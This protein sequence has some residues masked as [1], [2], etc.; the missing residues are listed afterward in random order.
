[1]K[2]IIKKAK[3]IL[4]VLCWIV[5]CVLAISIVMAFVARINGTNPTIL[6]YSVFRISSGSMEPELLVG[7]V[8]LGKSAT[9]PEEIKVGDVVTYKGSG[10]LEGELITHKVIIA[11]HEE[12]GT[13]MLQ[14]QGTANDIP[15]APIEAD[16]VISVMVR[17][18]PFL[19]HFYNFFLSPWGLLAII[20]L[21]VFVFIDELIL[22]IKTITGK[23][24]VKNGENIN[25]IIERL[26]AEKAQQIDSTADNSKSSRDE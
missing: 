3:K 25:E 19:N 22:F 16:R 17:K 10:N 20:A 18:L 6:G 11:P 7:D 9:A 12:D 26:Q 14:T 13:I 15:D 5:I 8:I 24:S 2:R 4:N 21:I 23:N 1:M